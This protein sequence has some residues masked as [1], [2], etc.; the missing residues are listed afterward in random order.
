MAS[1]TDLRLRARSRQIPDGMFKAEYTGEI[2]PANPDEREIPDSHLGT[3]A[4][5]VEAWVEQMAKGMGYAEVVW[6]EAS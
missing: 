6:E 5:E 2:N 4:R 3:S 1:T